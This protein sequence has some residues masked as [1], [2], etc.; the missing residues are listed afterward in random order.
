MAREARG[1]CADIRK[2]EEVIFLAFRLERGRGDR[3]RSMSRSSDGG[4]A[5]SRFGAFVVHC[6]TEISHCIETRLR[7]RLHCGAVERRSLEFF[8]SRRYVNII[9]EFQRHLINQCLE[10]SPSRSLAI[11]FVMV[12]WSS[13][14]ICG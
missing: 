7:G 4:R 9:K 8:R 12:S 5:V 1:W 13:Q 3:L 11:L 10:R 2:G 14:E 6:V